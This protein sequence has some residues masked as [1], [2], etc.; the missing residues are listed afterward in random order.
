NATVIL[1]PSIGEKN[2]LI[3]DSSGRKFGDAGFYFLLND[4]KG[5]YWSQ[6]IKAFTDKLVV[7]EERNN[8]KA[9][10]T[11]KLWNIKVANFEYVIE[12]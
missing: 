10:Q 6:Y 5:N 4:S 12:K 1:K 8:L 11:L 7:S 9:N 3:L 2:E